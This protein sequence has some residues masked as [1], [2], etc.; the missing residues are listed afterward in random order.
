M[1]SLFSGSTNIKNDGKFQQF[2]TKL[3]DEEVSTVRMSGENA[4]RLIHLYDYDVKDIVTKQK[5]RHWWKHA[6]IR[7]QFLVGSLDRKQQLVSE[8]MNE[9]AKQFRGAPR[10]VMDVRRA[11][12]DDDD[13]NGNDDQE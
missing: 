10:A 8:L 3:G 4:S 13:D 5:K 12:Y 1:D 2:I 9:V 6:K 7:A 11:I